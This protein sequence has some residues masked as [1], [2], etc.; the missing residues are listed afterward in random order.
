MQVAAKQNA[1]QHLQ[2]GPDAG[3]RAERKRMDGG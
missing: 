3:I 2:K 1:D